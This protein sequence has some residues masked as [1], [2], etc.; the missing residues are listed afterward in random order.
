MKKSFKKLLCTL[1]ALMMLT[2]TVSLAASAL[3]FDVNYFAYTFAVS[4][5]GDGVVLTKVN[6]SLLLDG[7]VVIPSTAQMSNVKYRV[8]GIG[9]SAFAGCDKLKTVTIPEG[10]KS[11]GSKAF[12]NCVGLTVVNIPKSLVSCDYDAFTGCGTVT[13][14]CYKSNY[15]FITVCALNS[16]LNLNIIDKS[17]TN[18]DNTDTDTDNDPVSNVNNIF[19]IVMSF[20]SKIFE[21]IKSIFVKAA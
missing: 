4:A 16:N 6:N 17:N 3:E 5:D 13:A 7:N 1:L 9:V 2:G 21:L 12:E 18:P 19:E 11:I 10:V 8:V 14:N 15:Q 20:I